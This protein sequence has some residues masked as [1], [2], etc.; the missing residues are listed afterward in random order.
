MPLPPCAGSAAVANDLINTLSQMMAKH[1]GRE[2]QVWPCEQES[3][4]KQTD[5]KCMSTSVAMQDLE[6]EFQA[7]RNPALVQGSCASGTP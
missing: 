1:A 4:G 5:E 2:R 3:Y 6:S 7:R